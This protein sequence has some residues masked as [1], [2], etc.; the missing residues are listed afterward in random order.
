MSSNTAIRVARNR[1]A[2][3]EGRGTVEN[4]QCEADTEKRHG[5]T[6]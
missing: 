3:K 2:D 1:G 6:H 5:E 4:K